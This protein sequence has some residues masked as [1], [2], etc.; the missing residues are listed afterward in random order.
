MDGTDRRLDPISASRRPIEGGKTRYGL[1]CTGADQE[2]E[3]TDD[4]LS[5]GMQPRYGKLTG[6]FWE[7]GVL[8]RMFRSG[9]AILDKCH[10]E[11]SWERHAA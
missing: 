6:L 7:L 8:E 5:R 10:R 1:L 3:R 2:T 4:V 9:R 11:A